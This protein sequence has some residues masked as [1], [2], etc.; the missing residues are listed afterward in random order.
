MKNSFVGSDIGLAVLKP[1]KNISVTKFS[2]S[3]FFAEADGN[4]VKLDADEQKLLSELDGKNTLADITATRLEK[5]DTAVF[6]RLITLIEK[7][8][9]NGLLDP[10][11]AGELKKA[12]QTSTFFEKT[13]AK[14]ELR[15]SSVLAALGKII[16]SVPFLAVMAAVSLVSFLTPSLKGVNILTSITQGSIEHGE[17]YLFA[18]FFILVFLFVIL[19]L[20]AL[21]SAAALEAAGIK[22]TVTLKCRYG[23]FYLTASS[24]Q[25]IGKGKSAALKHYAMILLTPFFISGITALLWQFG[26]ARPAMAV[27]NIIAVGCGLVALSPVSSSPLAM[28]IDFSMPGTMKSFNY[29]RKHFIKDILAL[30]KLSP[31]TERMMILSSIGLIWIYLVYSYFWSIA[32]STMSYLFSDIYAAYS[33][34]ETVSAVLAALTLLLLITPAVAALIGFIAIALGNIESVVAT[35]LVKMR[36]IAGRITAKSI[37]A[38][39]EIIGF[40]KEIPLFSELRDEEF[41]ELCKYIK[42]RRFM[43]NSP[44]IRQGDKGDNFYTIVSGRAKVVVSGNNG[45]EKIVGILSTGDSFGETALIEKGPRTASI[46]TLTPVAVFEIT[47]EGFEKFLASNAENREKITGKIRLGKM[48][49]ASPVFSFMSQKQISY[50]IKNLK[51]ERIKA[52]TTVFKQG[53][54]GDKF[55]LIQEGNIH[56]ERFENSLRTLDVILKHGNFFGEMALVKNIPRTATAE[57]VNDCLLFSLDK[58]TFCNIIG[59]SLFGGKELD[60]IINERALHLGTEVLK[61]CSRK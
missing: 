8:N 61:S 41:T 45:S 44:I 54:P 11:C 2:E 31:E 10:E 22:P 59:N 24:A 28:M 19:S 55:Y 38:T 21:C 39:E 9:E 13:L 36:D 15:S 4:F 32:R 17:A 5:G 58:E 29:I 46:V 23:L 50:L 1:V 57:T 43:K 35:P 37:P 6:D 12:D 48:L 20:P 26:I 52:G 51:P 53:D 47:K 25:I 49:L 60:L 30:R 33:G 42:L 27:M 3:L 34:G 40:L 16:T 14:K 18:L 7:L 56:L